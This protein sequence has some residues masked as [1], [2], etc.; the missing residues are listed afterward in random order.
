MAAITKKNILEL[1]ENLLGWYELEKRLFPWRKNGLSDYELVIAEVL[2]QRT[3][4]ETVAG[5]YSK[6]VEDYPSWESITDAGT[7]RIATS[8]KPIGL[9]RQRAARLLRL[10]T[11]MV[12]REGKIPNTQEELDQIPFM[13]QYIVN[14]VRLIIHGHRMPL[15]DVN[16]AR[17]LERYFRERDMADIRYDP[18]LQKL[19]LRFADH[20]NS[21]ELNWAMLDFAALICRARNPKCADCFLVLKC[22]YYKK[23]K[24][25]TK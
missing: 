22:A 2:L 25:L 16:M 7:D 8:L 10:A 3:K 5:F 17:V 21:K 12:K 11:E 18:F 14:A 19:A 23:L 24:K 4:A 13:G 6:F 1:Q 20:P 15:I 9:Y